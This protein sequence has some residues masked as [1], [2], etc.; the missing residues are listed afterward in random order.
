[1]VLDGGVISEE[2][3]HEELLEK[4]GIYRQ[5]FETQFDIAADMWSGQAS[6]SR[7]VMA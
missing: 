5:L 2:G 3:T 7:A 4:D 1:M 6:C